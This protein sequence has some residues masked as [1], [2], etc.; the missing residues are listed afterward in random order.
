M[1]VSQDILVIDDEPAIV[2]FMTEAL[3]DEGYSVRSALDGERALA[4]IA[5]SPPALVLLDLHLQGMLGTELLERLQNEGSLSVPVVLMTAD[6]RAAQTLAAHN[7]NFMFLV[8]PFNLE[9]LFTLVALYVPSTT[10]L[11]CSPSPAS[12]CGGLPG[13]GVE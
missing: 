9:D 12:P 7:G 10:G 3:T 6:L 4:E 5:A 1:R 11:A 13:Q 2:A 8:K